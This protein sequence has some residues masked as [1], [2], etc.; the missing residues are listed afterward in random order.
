ML[1]KAREG[2]AG[3]VTGIAYHAI[4]RDRDG[5]CIDHEIVSANR[6]WMDLL[7]LEEDPVGSRGNALL[8]GVGP[9]A[10][11]IPAEVEALLR[12]GGPRRIHLGQGNRTLALE[13]DA[14]DSGGFFSTLRDVTTRPNR[15]P[16]VLSSLTAEL[17]SLVHPIDHRVLASAFR[18]LSGAAYVGINLYDEDRT[19]STTAAL[20][21]DEAALS[22]AE[23]ILGVSLEGAQWS[24]D[25]RRIATIESGRPVRFDGLGA[26]SMG[27]LPEDALRTIEDTLDLGPI[28]VIMLTSGEGT[29]VGD[30]IL[31]MPPGREIGCSEELEIYAGHV[32]T[33][34]VR[35]RVQTRLRAHNRHFEQL[36]EGLEEVFWIRSADTEEMLY[37]SPAYER[38]WGRSRAA[39]YRDPS[40]F[41]ASILPED[42]PG[43]ARAYAQ[44]A[45]EGHFDM[46]Y[47]I[48]RPDDAVRWIWAR[49]FPVRDGEGR[50]VRNIG[51][52]MDITE[53][54]DHA[55]VLAEQKRRFTNLVDNVP[56]AI[57]RCKPD[58]HWTMQY[59]SD[60]ITDI[61][62]YPPADFLG[63]HR[64]TFQSVIHE[65]DRDA[66]AAAVQGSIERDEPYAVDYRVRHADGGHRWV[67]ENGRAMRDETG[68]PCFLD[69]AIFDVTDEHGRARALR[70]NQD[71]LSTLL[72]ALP[73]MVF[74][75]GE[76]GEFVNVFTSTEE[77]LYLPREELVGR[78][79]DTI[80]PADL[81][82]AFRAHIQSVIR[83]G[84]LEVLEYSLPGETHDH[85]F[86][87][88]TVPL[89]QGGVLAVV[90]DVTAAKR[91]EQAVLESEQNLRAT[92]DSIG[93]AVVATDVRGCVAWMNPVAESLTGWPI[94]D[95]LGAPI[96]DIL[97]IVHAQTGEPVPN[98][99]IEVLRSGRVV[100]LEDDSILLTRDGKQL[101]IADSAAPITD[102][103]GEATGVVMVFRDITEQRAAERALAESRRQLELFFSQSISGFFFSELPRPIH[104]EV[105]RV[106]QGAASEM[107]RTLQFTRV[108]RAMVKQYRAR[109]DR[110]FVGQ[111]VA[112]FFVE[113]LPIEKEHQL[114]REGSLRA[115]TRERRLDGSEIWILG[116]YR[117]VYDGDY[118]I[119]AF[120]TQSDITARKMTEHALRDSEE[121]YR[122][123]V[124]HSYDIIYKTDDAGRL[125]FV[126]PAWEA[127][128]G[129]PV[130]EVMGCTME[131]FAHP[132][133]RE[134]CRSFFSDALAG[135]DAGDVAECRVQHAD[136]SWRWH[137]IGATPLRD[138]GAVVG[139]VGTS[140]DIT[141]RVHADRAREESEQQFRH[142]FMESPVSI[143][144]HDHR[145]GEIVDANPNAWKMY[146]LS[147]LSELQ[148]N[149]F[150]LA[151][152]YGFDEAL[153]N[154]R[155][156]VREG[157]Q[158]FEWKNRD[159]QGRI[160]WELVRLSPVVVDGV[161]R[162]MATTIDITEQKESERRL[163]VL[164][165]R[166][167]E[168]TEKA[169][170]ANRAKADFLANMSH[171]VRTPLNGILGMTGLLLDSGIRGEGRRY[172][173]SIHI[174]GEALLG[175]INDI[176]D[177]SKIE[178]GR[179]EM[180]EIDFDLVGLVEDFA[181]SMALRAEEGGLELLSYVHPGIPETLRGDP[182]RIRQIL[183]NLVGN[184]I[185]FTPEGQVALSVHPVTTGDDEGENR[186]R[187]M[188][189]VEDTGIGIP[190]DK[191]QTL[192]KRFTQVDSST[193]R[194]YGG[195]GLG[196]AIS[197]ELVTRMD[198]E[199]GVDSREG[200]GSTFW[201]TISLARPARV[202]DPRPPVMEGLR[203]VRTLVVDDNATNRE[204]LS[205]MLLGWEMRTTTL[206][207]P[208]RAL[209][210]LHCARRSGDPFRLLLV[211]MQMP[212][213]DGEALGSLVRGDDR[214]RDLRLV[215]LTSM[216]M[217]GQPRRLA[218]IGFDGYLSKP[219]RRE[220]LRGVLAL[221]MEGGDPSDDALGRSLA[222]RHLVR[223]R[224]R[225]ATGDG[226]RVL[227]VE[228]NPT[229]QE[230][231]LGI[232]G[233][234]GFQAR[235]VDD[236][237]RALEVLAEED[238]DAVLMDVQMPGM[239]G[240]ETT[241]RIRDS[242][243]VRDPGVPIIALTAHALASDREA[244]LE[245]GM[246]DYLA[247][248]VTP[249]AMVQT[250][251]R[252]L[253]DAGS[254]E[255]V[256]TRDGA[257]LDVRG[258]LA[259][260][261][262]DEALARDI[263]GGFLVDAAEQLDAMATHRTDGDLAGVAVIAHTL[264]GAAAS[265]SA[266]PMR[267]A[268]AGVETAARDGNVDAVEAAEA[269]LRHALSR[270]EKEI[271]EIMGEDSP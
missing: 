228:D 187:L 227:V 254:G 10:A 112:D 16:E 98:P 161:K 96:T 226:R 106:D 246:D 234:L 237:F 172:A 257:I 153:A 221:A 14:S 166:L 32:A 127:M 222:T 271:E 199:M 180:E 198:G 82:E 89:P 52:A 159:I 42:R 80:F 212:G 12:E 214:L 92:L 243:E 123:L 184:A 39:L 210:V 85:W 131:D 81:A 17:V 220:E 235:G 56:G 59:L 140:Q 65:A 1:D 93:D 68:H 173:E 101:D 138:G 160:F 126:S 114:F 15:D 207:D 266:E 25:P 219:I 134:V 125:T 157:P 9:D 129:H 247:K 63:N 205:S 45:E 147:S 8:E 211:D 179:L 53:R 20:V 189:T 170:D 154:I 158:Q 244:C 168:E 47:R 251:E 223:E 117:C 181:D 194:K 71:Y 55:R 115:E 256:G 217:R 72:E 31:L 116:D 177:F 73:D 2:A 27:A 118:I 4:I 148:N 203:G 190:R 11:D 213:M 155:R 23:S 41:F 6:A 164:N 142:L 61:T 109:D 269:T 264:K 259:R 146:G 128:L 192:F 239:D 200:E 204:I 171:E 261:M 151:S 137:R 208:S 156:A 176:L 105:A 260:T 182:G 206:E 193:T 258:L 135:A 107:F 139:V 218:D 49:S 241:R 119:G 195:T 21:G 121:R 91:T 38:I 46:E 120:G 165:R 94:R 186:M 133:D 236:G 209:E 104:R 201:F 18:R 79:V 233:N 24:L 77:L 167:A 7:G 252:V 28:Y 122:L 191:L 113:N 36:A 51:M 58:A 67:R 5:V 84:A 48:L 78:R 100:E 229:N 240:M 86:E 178:A 136:G 90:V 60:A 215:M 75:L 230:V 248:P 185:K 225:R 216:A 150:W 141:E 262:G 143:I 95:A 29:P 149:A 124:D 250:L 249:A 97:D 232:L 263:L 253:E 108:N 66:V 70:E 202:P 103:T 19:H 196:L 224:S 99:A 13:L 270:L 132:S 3:A 87:A 88:R 238:Y 110:D 169:R 69:G 62:G 175:L 188:F 43:V 74:H 174:S 30:A 26:T 245:A 57:F 163:Q 152:P 33:L 130:C 22:R 268:A 35:D 111:R 76:D 40:E 83:G 267:E 54:K 64:R 197:R 50:V 231:A 145:T 265:V 102:E 144:I 162:V 34:L 183:A 242:R 255:E 37:I 44:Y